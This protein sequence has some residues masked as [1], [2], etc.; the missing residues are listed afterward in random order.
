MTPSR[1][2]PGHPVRAGSPGTSWRPGTAAGS[3]ARLSSCP[4]QLNAANA[5]ALT[6]SQGSADGVPGD[7]SDLPCGFEGYLPDD[8]KLTKHS[9]SC[10]LV[11]ELRV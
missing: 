7:R 5:G 2:P 4:I 10:P 9:P 11:L 8:S 3:P 1:L 6:C